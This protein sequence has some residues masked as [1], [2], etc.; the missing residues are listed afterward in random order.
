MALH[1]RFDHRFER[2]ADALLDA[3]DGSAGNPLAESTVIVPSVGVGRWLQRRDASR[4]GV[5]ARIRPEFPGR[6]LWRTMRS[7]MPDLPER[8]PFEP[9]R[10]RWV[11]M[12]LLGELP[13]HADFEL[14]R[15]RVRDE[16]SLERLSL[17]D[18]LAVRFERY[19]AYRRD[20]LAR[21]QRGQWAVGERP[22]GA[23]EPWQ[24]WLWQRLLERLPQVR[25]V[26]PYDQFARLLDGDDARLLGRFGERSVAILGRVDLSPEQFALLGRLASWM[27]VSFF[28]PDPCRELWTD[29]LDSRQLAAIREQ[30]PDVAWLYD[31]EPALLGNWGR[32]HRDF[33]AQLLS[34]EERF[35]TQAEAPGRDDA[36]PFGASGHG[37]A[38]GPLQ[39]LQAAVF[40]RSDAPWRDVV[41]DDG[42][43]AVIGAHGL[44]RQAELLHESLLEC[45]ETLPSLSPGEVVVY[46]ADLEAAASAIEG[47]FDS[48][49]EPRRI[50]I[51]ISGRAPRIDPLVAAVEGMLAMTLQGVSALA[52]DEWL[53]GPAVMEALALDASEVQSLLGWFDAAGARRGLDAEEGSPKHNVRTAV[54]RLLL[55][56]AMGEAATVG[57]LLSVPGAQGTRARA[58]DAWLRVGDALADLREAAREPHPLADWC[59]ALAAAVDSVFG[60]VRRHAGG[61][62]RVHDALSDLLASAA[63]MPAVALDAAAFGRAFADALARSATA[64]MPSGAVTV[65][66]IGSL[67]G[68]PFRVVCLFGMDEGAF[69]RKGGLDE[70]DLMRR[71]PRFGDR[72]A[73]IDDRGVFLDAVLAARDRLIVSCRSRNA[74]DDTPL[75]PSP[76]VGELLAY[77]SA[78]LAADAGGA[79]L[80][81]IRRRHPAPAAGPALVEYPLHPFSARSFAGIGS[82]AQE[83][84]A[85]AHGLARPLRERAPS[86][87]PL[88]AVADPGDVPV[89]AE[90]MP[91]T[92]PIESVR[93]ALAA[94]A[95]TW[96]RESLGLRLLREH[97]V[98]D[99]T[100]PLWSDQD[101][102]AWVQACVERLLAGTDPQR[103]V[104]EMAI[105]PQTAAGA[106]GRSHASRLVQRALALVAEAACGPT[107]SATGTDRIVAAVGE[108]RLTM[109]VPAL[110]ARQQ[111]VFASAFPLGPHALIDAW[112]RTALWR[113]AHGEGPPA[114]LVA[115]D[116][117]VELRVDD[118]QRS[119]RHALQW[120]SRIAR[121]PLALFPRSW[122]RYALELERPGRGGGQAAS[123]VGEQAAREQAARE[124]AARERARETLAGSEFGARSPELQRP[125]EQALFRDAEPDI[126]Q[127]LELGERAYR[128]MFDDIDVRVRRRDAT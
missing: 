88:V 86:V 114:R 116:A 55:G 89:Q 101:D 50:P 15:R 26:H 11:L 44:V 6:W 34:L 125:A 120:A 64:A 21:W 30:R 38:P 62:Q 71:A 113:D 121:E 31:G 112:L 110:D 67:P 52:L 3:L 4:H 42:S 82:Y 7:A 111:P 51:S 74:R 85:A 107:V 40:A 63:G 118:P 103:L 36:T 126:D 105:A 25:D 93:N 27:D 108:V 122:L 1:I 97:L 124:R 9:E 106:P 33:V 47:V 23:H 96:L 57:E 81:L 48:Q 69:P 28:A 128:P 54:E 60:T 65:C 5:S 24:R 10:V 13:G 80:D 87:G 43:V 91:V 16:G 20:W 84:V 77:L 102:R 72:L 98:P 95:A 12:E 99:E 18:A 35:E 17:A 109:A 127:V 37:T 78:R 29:M 104:D 2:L 70:L 115:L 22:L 32:A 76:L 58:L 41:R 45:F 117:T 90:T 123:P 79:P 119:L 83:W 56:A 49:P 73:R 59:A 53:R 94:P 14:L 8:S 100:E 19:L 92:L 66:P 46:C 68:V 39:A 75:N 61:L